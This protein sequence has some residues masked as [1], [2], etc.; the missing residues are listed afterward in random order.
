MADRLFLIDGHGQIY[1]AH[2]APMRQALTSP[3][4]EPTKV[5]YIFTTALLGLINRQRPDML[6][7]VMDSKGPTFRHG[8]YPAYKANRPPVPDEIPIQI[9]RIEQ[10]L[11]AMHIPLIRMDGFEADDLIGT[12]A[13]R[14]AQAGYECYICS[15]DKDVVQL[16]SEGVY[17]FDIKT[18]AVLSAQLFRQQTGI[19]P[20][21]YLDCLALQGD[22]SDNVPGVPDVGPK[23]ALEWIRRYGSIE[24]LY[25]HADQIPGKRGQQLRA[26]RHLV[27]LSRQ[28]VTIDCDVPLE[29]DWD[30]LRPRPFDLERLT[31]I[32][33]ELGF[34]RLLDQLDLRSAA[35][36]DDSAIPATPRGPH[37]IQTVPHQYRLVNTPEQ[38]RALLDQI[39]SVETIAVDTETTSIDPMRAELVG[40]S[41]CWQAHQAYYIPLK[42]PLGSRCL[43]IEQVKAGLGPLLSDPSVRK[44][45]QNIKFDML[46]LRN[47]GIP[48]RGVWFDTMVASYCLEPTRQSHSLDSLALDLLS[49]RCIPITDLIGKGR[50]AVTFDLVDLELACQYSAEDADI[51]FQIHEVLKKRLDQQQDLKDLFERVE[52]PLV[53]VLAE[54]EY[55]GVAVDLPFL[56]DLSKQMADA[57]AKVQQRIYELAGGPFNIDSPRQLGQVLFERLG[58]RPI[59]MGKTGLSTDAAVLDELA[60]AHPIIEQIMQYRQLTKL[61]GTYADKLGNLVNHRTGRVHTSF[62]QTVTATGRLSSS[63]PNL[64]NIPIRTDLGK[65]IRQAFIAQ[66]PDDC[67]LSADYSQV[68]LRILAHLSQDKTLMDAFAA[69]QDIHRFVASQIYNVPMDQVTEQMRSRCKA[70]NFGIIYGQGPAGLART[71]GLPIPEARRFI[72][73]Y[74]ARY[75]SI[76]DF[77]DKVVKQAARDGYVQTILHRRRPIPEMASSSPSIRARA[78]RLAVNTVIQGSAADLIK[79]A[80][81]RIH[82]KIQSDRLPVRMILQVHDELVFELPQQQVQQHAAWISSYMANALD[83]SVPLKVDVHYGRTWLG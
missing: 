18:E 25:R 28:L 71:T 14:A 13:R 39:R 52:M 63:D 75:R 51:T 9:A 73:E 66:D 64:Q 1:A 38:F 50:K 10:I 74:F 60:G 48:L 31:S 6:A 24:E 47:A 20:R 77:M 34:N 76:K 46:V 37:S 62:N 21:Q 58:L 80:M 35:K 57:I 23:T 55:N 68:E 2:Y 82:N 36:T 78:A 65:A 45:G 53:E 67:L 41:L 26:S 69:D 42:G 7:V 30:R 12:I 59:R 17:I 61:K 49:Y 27:D 11:D 54:M 22:P 8:L 29:I 72:K 15:K 79:L 83:L 70:V 3:S 56:K 32:F 5:T 16:L 44:I 4:G 19:S 81:I 33:T 43:G 40:I